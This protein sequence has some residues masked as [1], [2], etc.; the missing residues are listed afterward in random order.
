MRKRGIQ[1][2]VN[3]I[4]ILIIALAVFSFGIKMMYDLMYKAEEIR[5]DVDENTE[6]EIEAALAGGEIVSL[7]INHKESDVGESA[8]FGLG[9]FNIEETQDF[10]IEMDFESA[11]NQKTK[12]PI[13]VN[14]QEW[15]LADYGPYTIAKNEQ[16]IIALPIRIPK[17]VESGKTPPGVYS[18][19]VRVKRESGKQYGNLKKIRV[20]VT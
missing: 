5:Q 11:Y 2:S 12:A 8:T 19:N 9:I 14:G 6:R 13:S 7:P 3:F 18:F 15:I 17:N 20:S 10:T 4:V 1:L 16:K